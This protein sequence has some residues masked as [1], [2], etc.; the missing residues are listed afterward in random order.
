VLQFIKIRWSIPVRI[1]LV[2]DNR[3]LSDSLKLILQD[4]GYAVDTAYDGI[5]GEEAAML[6]GYDVIILDIML[7]G[8]DGLEVC[9]ELR[10]R[11]VN[12]P[13]L[14]LTARDALEDRVVGLDSGADDYLV[15]PFEVDELRARLRALLRRESTSKSGTLRIADLE[16]DPAAH[17]AQRAGQAIELTAKEFSLLEYLMRHPNRLVTREMAEEHLWSYDHV[18]ASN[19][20]DVYIRRLRRKIDDPWPDKL[21]ETVRGAGYRIRTP[22]GR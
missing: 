22:E 21:L 14:M 11:R 18:V 13:I 5:D 2:E 10:N 4:D 6:P 15:K 9:R 16:L 17:S 20:V 8:K 3:R 7:P 1:L 12:T 19:V